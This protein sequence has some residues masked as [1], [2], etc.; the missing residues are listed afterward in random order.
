MTEFC[1]GGEL[2]DYI[3]EKGFLP[4]SEA[5]VIMSKIV[6]A[7]LHL[8]ERNICH[9]DLKPEN[10]LFEVRGKKSEIKVIDFGLSKYFTGDTHMTTK[11]GT[12]YYVSPEVLEGRYDNSCDMWSIGVISFVMLCGYPPFNANNEQLLFRKIK[13]CDYDFNDDYWKD[14]S[15]EAKDFIRKCL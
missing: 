14:I 6:S 3:M 12:P 2:F 8:H 1:E 4:E 15:N 13:C 7:I 5:A 11:L 10:I 9:R